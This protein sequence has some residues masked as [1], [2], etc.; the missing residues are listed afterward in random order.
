[1]DTLSA[2]TARPLAVSWGAILFVIHSKYLPNERW[3]DV[4]FSIA[5]AAHDQVFS[6]FFWSTTYLYAN[7]R[8]ECNGMNL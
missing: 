5:V 6:T 4:F 7:F 1:M 3:I 2:S 8:E